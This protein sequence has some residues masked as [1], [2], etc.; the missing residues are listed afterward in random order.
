MRTGRTQQQ[1]N[2]GRKLRGQHVQHIEVQTR[3]ML[4]KTLNM[5]KQK[6]AVSLPPVFLAKA[7]QQTT[8]VVCRDVDTSKV[9]EYILRYCW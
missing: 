1:Y 4:N 5:G 3:V 2:V 8:T 9:T 6:R 7:H